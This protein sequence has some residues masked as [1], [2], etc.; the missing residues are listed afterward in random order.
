[1]S[2]GVGHWQAFPMLEGTYPAP[3]FL[4]VINKM[5]IEYL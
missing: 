2:W 1:M 4:M 3:N 5:L